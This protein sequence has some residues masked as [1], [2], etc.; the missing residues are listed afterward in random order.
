[1]ENKVDVIFVIMPFGERGTEEEKRLS[2]R[3][4]SVMKPILELYANEVKRSDEFGHMGSITTDIINYLFR[5]D[6]VIADLS[7]KNAN[8]FYE[9][10]VRHVLRKSP[11]IPIAINGEKIPF[12]ITTYR[13]IYFDDSENGYEML[14]KELIS[15]I[16]IILSQ[17]QSHIDNPVYDVLQEHIEDLIEVNSKTISQRNLFENECIRLRDSLDK[18]LQKKIILSNKISLLE[19]EVEK[20]HYL[21]SLY[22]QNLKGKILCKS[23]YFLNVQEEYWAN[24]L[25][26][27]KCLNIALFEMGTEIESITIKRISG[28]VEIN[29]DYIIL[30]R[31]VAENSYELTSTLGINKFPAVV[32]VKDGKEKIRLTGLQKEYV[33]QGE[34]NKYL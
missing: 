33:Y 29:S 25:L 14:K 32:F 2:Y 21:L 18:T 17:S 12:D 8:V 19:R 16:E 23:S 30:T 1:M 7:G 11:T 15:K 4:F 27:S 28:L 34:I 3:Y 6:I 9:L 31:Y 24:V 10:G 22:K 5:A 13:T 26:K 20:K